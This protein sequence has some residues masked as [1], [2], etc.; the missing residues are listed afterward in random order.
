MHAIMLL[1]VEAFARIHRTKS[2]VGEC[3]AAWHTK[4]VLVTLDQYN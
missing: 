2:H 3:S 4:R 1:V